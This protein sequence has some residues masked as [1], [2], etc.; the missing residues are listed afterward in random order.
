MSPL[1]DVPIFTGDQGPQHQ[2]WTAVTVLGHQNGDLRSPAT[3][4]Q[5]PYLILLP[6]TPPDTDSSRRLLGVFP[7]GARVRTGRSP[8]ARATGLLLAPGQTWRGAP[9]PRP[10]AGL[11]R[12]VWKQ[13]VLHGRARSRGRSALRIFSDYR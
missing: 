5:H 1:G 13:R 3:P 2:P 7:S 11:R 12:A 8:P 10:P 6:P 9:P 4:G